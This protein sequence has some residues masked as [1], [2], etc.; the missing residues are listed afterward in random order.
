[1]VTNHVIAD[2][3]KH[4]LPRLPPTNPVQP[5]LR[6]L[7]CTIVIHCKIF[8]TRH[9]RNEETNSVC[10]RGVQSLGQCLWSHLRVWPSTPATRQDTFISNISVSQHHWNLCVIASPGLTSITTTV[11][12]KKKEVRILIISIDSQRIISINFLS[13]DKYGVRWELEE[14]ENCEKDAV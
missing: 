10:D 4:N 7:H 3:N 11:R 12:S 5:R 14:L 6:D 1:M 9:H 8:E 2:K 13:S